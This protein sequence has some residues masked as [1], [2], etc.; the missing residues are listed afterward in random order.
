MIFLIR[1][2][3]GTGATLIP[4]ELMG[5]HANRGFTSFAPRGETAAGTGFHLHPHYRTD[6]PL[7]ATLLKVQAG[8][9]DFITEKY[10]DE[11]GAI[12]AE[13]SA[14]LLQSPRDVE[15]I[16]KVLAPGFS[17]CFAPTHGVASCTVQFDLRGTR[18]QICQRDLAGSRESFLQELQSALSSFSAGS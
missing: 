3:Q 9:D 14:G 15:P 11:V 17:G 2:C 5:K 12:L 13:W 1:F 8:L 18:K 16:A 6:R 4:G 7:D 10:A